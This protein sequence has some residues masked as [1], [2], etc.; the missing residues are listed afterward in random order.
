MKVRIPKT[1]LIISK[2]VKEK[3]GTKAGKDKTKVEVPEQT[4]S[5]S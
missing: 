1:S 2:M 4:E 3:L 5:V